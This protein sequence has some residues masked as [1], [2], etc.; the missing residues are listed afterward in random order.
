MG[1]MNLE[2]Y[3][4]MQNLDSLR[5]LPTLL[6]W[7]QF[8]GS[9][10]KGVYKK[11]IG[12]IEVKT[13]LLLIFFLLLLQQATMFSDQRFLVPSTSADENANESEPENPRIELPVKDPDDPG[14]YPAI[15]GHAGIKAAS[16]LPL[17]AEYTRP[18][19][20]ITYLR[21]RSRSETLGLPLHPS[22]G[23]V[24]YLRREVERDRTESVRSLLEDALLD[25]GVSI[26]VD[27]PLVRVAEQEIA[28]AFDVSED[29]LHAA[30]GRI[31]AE[32][33][34]RDSCTD[35]EDP[36]GDRTAANSDRSSPTVPLWWSGDLQSG[37]D[38]E[39]IITDL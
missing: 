12:V 25:E 5:E 9:R 21:Q 7:F 14:P 6:P 22:S 1:D 10:M 34:D 39:L 2:Q 13:P 4:Y 27:D 31:L 29:E 8:Y 38:S 11:R 30:A 32:A 26:T 35:N 18:Y 19:G 15:K 33:G 3:V 36:G 23:E 28:E 37:P 24:S 16:S 20:P 17:T